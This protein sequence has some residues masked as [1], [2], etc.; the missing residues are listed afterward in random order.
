MR[1]IFR[2]ARYRS[3]FNMAIHPEHEL[4]S[5]R[6]GRNIAVGLILGGF[7]LLVFAVSVVKLSTPQ[8]EDIYAPNYS[9]SAGGS[10]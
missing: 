3:G 2:S 6:K 1:L 10:E 4:H 5:R 7:V 9:T 8:N